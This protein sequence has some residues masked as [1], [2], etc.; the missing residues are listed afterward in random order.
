MTTFVWQNIGLTILYGKRKCIRIIA[1][2]ESVTFETIEEYQTYLKERQELLGYC[3]KI[4]QG[5]ENLDEKSGERAIWE[6]VQNARDMDENCR[7]RIELHKD[8]FIF[9][10]HGKPFN[11]LSLLALVNQNSSKDNPGADLVGQYGTGFMT[12]HAFNSK[13]VVD[14]PYEVMSN[15]NTLKGYVELGGFELDRSFC[16]SDNIEQAIC[17]MHKEMKLVNEMYKKLPI[18]PELP[19]KWTSFT[20]S[21]EPDKVVA[22]S[23][24]LE[25]AVRFMP[26]VLTI[27]DRIKEVE[28]I[29]EFANKHYRIKKSTNKQIAPINN[30][31]DWEI[32]DNGIEYTYFNEAQPSKTSKIRSLQ[33]KDGKD[34]VILP[35]FPQESGPVSNIP[36][37]F[38]WFPLLGTEHFGVNFIFHS[39]RFYPVEKR[40]NI[41]LPENVQ[42]KLEKG[43]VNEG[44]LREIMNVLFDYYTQENNDT[45]LSREM[46]VVNFHSDKDDEVTTKFYEDM[47]NL[48][49]MHIPNWNIIPT[50]EGKK[51]MCDSRVRVLHPDFYQKLTDEQR[52][53]YEQTLIKYATQVRYNEQET[54]L[55][56]TA[57][58]IAWSETIEQWRCHRD[59]EFYITVKDVC[60]SIQQKSDELHEFLSFLVD[61]GNA[62]FLDSYELLPNRKGKLK[63]KGDLRHGD[64]MTAELYKLTELLMGSDADRM[65]DTLYNDIGHVSSYE[66]DDLQRSIGQTVSEWRATAL[67]PNKVPLT[68]NQ[69]NALIAFCSATSQVGLTNYRGRMMNL[70][71]K[72]HGMEFKRVEQP[73]IVENEDDFY[74]SAFNLLLDYTLYIISTKDCNWVI[75]NKSLLHDFLTEYATSSAKERLERLDYY[76]VI[77]NQ[78][79]ELHIKKEL[80]KNVNIDIRLADIYK[81]VMGT[82]L[83]DKWVSTDF[84][85]IF[86]Y[87]EQKA[88]EVANEIQ[89]K[90]SDGD[91]Q[92]AIVLDII[93]LAENENTDSWKILFKT[94]Y[95]QR[96]S[97][98]YKLGTPEERKA[99]NRMMKKKSPK[100]LNLMADIVE[101]SDAE[102]LLSN[103]N[104]VISQMEHEAYIQ[105]LGAYVEKHIGLYLEEAF[106][107]MEVTVSNNQC[108]Q[109]FILSKNGCKDYHIEV[110]S[111]WE[112]DQSVEMSATQFKCAVENSDCYA[113][114][115][116]NMYHFDRKRAEENDP[117]PFSEICSNI[118]VLDNIGK[119]EA[120]LYRRADEAFRDDQ[121]EICLNGTYKVRVSQNVFDK[122]PLDFNGLI[123]RIRLHFCQE[124]K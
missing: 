90:L 32:V 61:S 19:N 28:V 75:N 79:N 84:S 3:K 39:K 6:L 55:L 63:K 78:N 77:P 100:L 93:E 31:S 44:V 60:Q 73:K 98:R 25:S 5:I 54:F 13:V 92:D 67:G 117:L 82:D 26:F 121:T 87:N 72:F 103:V 49:K 27:N 108:G 42:S 41:L 36:S 104:T 69:L 66:V 71:T 91:F 105:M 101:R 114:I 81:Q 2:R 110:K 58:P 53:K 11:Y 96:E 88:S 24:Q 107:G 106:K 12:T 99:I 35:P 48:W 116:V 94:I 68:H 16:G 97:I 112:S 22:V 111:R 45:S 85:A 124:G 15:P 17:E 7:I 9:M 59:L 62:S 23:S 43:K 86:T 38:L 29:D 102:E 120:D 37:L 51:A 47:Q 56:P 30:H 14:G 46:C 95:N 50:I 89:N 21:L 10:H 4:S 33:S 109:D 40:N 1:M 57:E 34:M 52:K 74:K 123:S 115:N 83:H 8:K 118:K 122:Y 18:Y 70:I 64:F 113:L 80:Y 65:I 20:Y 119:L 76:G